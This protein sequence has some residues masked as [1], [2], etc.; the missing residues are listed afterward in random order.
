MKVK[1]DVLDLQLHP[2]LSMFGQTFHVKKTRPL[3]K[4]KAT[5]L[6]TILI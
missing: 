6:D 5:L 1:M 4:R 2:C 3:N